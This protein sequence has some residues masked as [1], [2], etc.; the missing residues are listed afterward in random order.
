M[1]YYAPS[2]TATNLSSTSFTR[3]STPAMLPATPPTLLSIVFVTFRSCAAA[4][5]ASSCVSLSSL[6]SASSISVFPISF[7]RYVSEIGSIG[8]ILSVQ[9][10]LTGPALFEFL[11]RNSKDVKNLDHYRRDRVR[12]FLIWCQFNVYLEPSEKS[13]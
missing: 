12:H 5:R 3:S 7:F 6:F 4:I 9:Q 8:V 13:L 10:R 2:M 11:C 1:I